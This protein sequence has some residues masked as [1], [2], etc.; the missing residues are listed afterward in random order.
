MTARDDAGR[1]VGYLSAIASHGRTTMF[2]HLAAV[3]GAQAGGAMVV[4][5]MK[6]TWAE[7]Q[8]DYVKFY[9]LANNPYPS[10]I[11]GSFGEAFDDGETCIMRTVAHVVSTVDAPIGAIAPH[12]QVRDASRS[13]LQWV[14]AY[15]RRHES[16][17]LCL[18]EDLTADTLCLEDLNRRYG[19]AGLFRHRRVLIAY[20]DSD[21]VGFA[22]ADVSSPGLNL[23]EGLSA[24]RT[25]VADHALD[26]DV[27]IR[28]ALVQA[29]QQIYRDAGRRLLLGLVGVDETPAYLRLGFTA[30]AESRCI[31]MHRSRF[32][33]FAEHVGRLTRWR[34]RRFPGAAS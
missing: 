11:Y 16:P 29:V 4:E 6:V 1:P 33:D 31:L 17:L 7:P 28:A 15:I 32:Q 26:L 13:D 14:E 10:R 12:L 19:K 2:Q 22:L 25:V 23:S 34:S 18:A 3:R 20:R 8:F 5:L 30:P 24:F 9:F 21:P 27:E